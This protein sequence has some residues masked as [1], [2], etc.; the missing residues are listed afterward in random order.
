MGDSRETKQ[1]RAVLTAVK[2]SHNHPSAEEVHA[3]VRKKLPSVSLATVYRNLHVL[4]KR[5]EIKELRTDRE[6]RFD[7][8]TSPHA[9]FVCTVCG[10]VSDVAEKRIGDVVVRAGRKMGV[11]DCVEITFRGKCRSCSRNARARVMSSVK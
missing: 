8:M 2:M 6:A 7:G 11:V 4:A 10:R 9:H 5:G 1:R 3:L